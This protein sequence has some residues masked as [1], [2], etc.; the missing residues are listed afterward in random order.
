MTGAAATIPYYDAEAVARATPMPALIAALRTAFA[1]GDYH[2]PPIS[3][4]S[5]GGA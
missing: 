5:R 2:A 3:A 4:A 1:S